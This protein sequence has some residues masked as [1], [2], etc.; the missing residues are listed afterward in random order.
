MNEKVNRLS[1][2]MDANQQDIRLRKR[3]IRAFK[4]IKG[5]S[6]KTG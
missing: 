3:Q 2:V 6:C 1:I 4:D 5:D